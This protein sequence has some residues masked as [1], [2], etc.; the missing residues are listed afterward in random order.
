MRR[1]RRKR[2]EKRGWCGQGHPHVPPQPPPQPT[3]LGTGSTITTGGTFSTGSTLG[4]SRDP[5]LGRAG[6]DEALGGTILLSPA[7]ALPS[8]GCSV[9]RC[10]GWVRLRHGKADV[11]GPVPPNTHL[12]SSFTR[13]SSQARGAHGAGGATLARGAG[14]T[15]LARFTL[16]S[17]EARGC[18]TEHPARGRGR[19]RHTRELD[20]GGVPAPS[21]PAAPWYSQRG[22]AG[23]G[24][25]SRLSVR[26]GRRR[27]A[28]RQ[29]PGVRGCRGRPVRG[30]HGT[31]GQWQRRGRPRWRGRPRGA[32]LGQHGAARR[33][34]L[35]GGCPT[36]G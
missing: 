33:P 12:T 36:G 35:R 4:R 20:P 30:T 11:G 14:G 6:G 8:I 24:S 32:R 25:L 7:P 31:S 18:H 1:R 3:H 34:R 21:V 2:T 28:G 10:H 27:R 5:S 9:R 15:L 29:Y 26:G 23:R 22:R 16:R 17:G 13:G 19:G